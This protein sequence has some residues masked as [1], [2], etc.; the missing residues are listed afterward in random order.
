[1]CITNRFLESFGSLSFS[2][3]FQEFDIIEFVTCNSLGV[4]WTITD[5]CNFIIESYNSAFTLTCSFGHILNLSFNS[6]LYALDTRYISLIL[7]CI[8]Q[9]LIR[10]IS[11]LFEVLIEFRYIVTFNLMF[12]F[13]GLWDTHW[14]WYVQTEYNWDVLSSH[15]ILLNLRSCFNQICDFISFWDFFVI[16]HDLVSRITKFTYPDLILT[17]HDYLTMLAKDTLA[18][19]T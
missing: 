6:S 3:G 10:T 19:F 8:T 7:F 11:K 14:T 2:I 15:L 12:A 4:F 16:Y 17:F 1:M 13:Y 18:S 9:E 5:D